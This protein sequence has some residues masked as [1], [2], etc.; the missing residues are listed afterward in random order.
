MTFEVSNPAS[1]LTR[2]IAEHQ[3]NSLLARSSHVARAAECESILDAIAET[4]GSR[5]DQRGWL[6]R[7]LAIAAALVVLA[8]MASSWANQAEEV[9]SGGT[10]L[11]ATSGSNGLQLSEHARLE[12]S[13][14]ARVRLLSVDHDDVS[15]TLES[16]RVAAEFEHPSGGGWKWYA[17]PYLVR[18]ATASLS[19]LWEP[20][21][22]ALEL[23]IL[24][25]QAGVEG[26]GIAHGTR[27]N[28]GEHLKLGGGVG[29]P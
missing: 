3:D 28:A 6:L 23:T 13:D 2:A 19:V 5:R 22:Q 20:Q 7:V 16:G 26:P 27:L 12:L 25:G 10:W 8:A 18:G 29:R 4:E 9:W 14:G 11:A 24:D 15:L 21:T 17:G 1:R